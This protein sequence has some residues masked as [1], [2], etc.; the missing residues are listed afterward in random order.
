MVI[1]LLNETP[2]TRSSMDG[3]KGREGG[4]GT[5]GNPYNCW[6]KRHIESTVLYTL[7]AKWEQYCSSNRNVFARI[8]SGCKFVAK[9]RHIVPRLTQ[10]VLFKEQICIHSGNA[11]K[12]FYKRNKTVL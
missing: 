3:T 10:F 6:E 11:Q 1:P 5:V 4:G 7:N 12:R 8:Q 9:I 2:K